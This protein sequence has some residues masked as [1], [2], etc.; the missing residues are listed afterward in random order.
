MKP[1]HEYRS[2]GPQDDLGRAPAGSQPAMTAEFGWALEGLAKEGRSHLATKRRWPEEQF[3]GLSTRQAPALPS[4]SD[5]YGHVSQPL[6][7]RSIAIQNL[8][9]PTFVV[10]CYRGTVQVLDPL[11][12][13]VRGSGARAANLQHALVYLHVK[14]EDSC[15]ETQAHCCSWVMPNDELVV[16]VLVFWQCCRQP[17]HFDLPLATQAAPSTVYERH[18]KHCGVRSKTVRPARR[19]RYR[20]ASGLREIPVR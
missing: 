10:D 13:S 17:L 19:A 12:H 14:G 2:R 15:K 16:S 3:F 20:E 1:Q 4:L 5:W 18:Q 8:V 9:A 11:R 7:C 6:P